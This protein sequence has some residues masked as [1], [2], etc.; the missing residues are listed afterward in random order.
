MP[1]GSDS[2]I[3]TVII[4]RWGKMVIL[5]E[6]ALSELWFRQAYLN[7]PET[8][9]YNHAWGGVI[10]F[11][12]EEWEGWYEHWL[13]RHEGRRFFRYLKDSETGSFLGEIAYHY[14]GS[15]AIWLADVIVK[16]EYRGR[17]FGTEGLRLLCEEAAKRG[18][19]FLYDDIALDN[20]GIGIF[21]KA[22]FAEE[23]RTAEVIMLK[24]DLGKATPPA[25]DEGR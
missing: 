24:K 6:P 13:V 5:H 7:D 25:E 1:D 21:L 19:D 9:S 12:R 16:D 4:E 17:G 18:V 23:Y 11:P 14:D 8:M 3:I 10:P 15:R 22:G 2:G 20:P